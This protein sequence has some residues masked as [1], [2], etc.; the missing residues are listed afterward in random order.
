M[1]KALHKD[2]DKIKLALKKLKG[3]DLLP[4][5]MNPVDISSNASPILMW[6]VQSMK[7][8]KIYCDGE[9]YTNNDMVG[10]FKGFSKLRNIKI[11]YVV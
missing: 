6:Y 11:I 8:I 10:V 3:E 1:N 4:L 7:T 9:I 2:T 5:T